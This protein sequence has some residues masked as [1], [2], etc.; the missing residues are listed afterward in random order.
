VVGLLWKEGK[1]AINKGRYFKLQEKARRGG[2]REV[3]D[4]DTFR[5]LL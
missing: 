4:I 2:R 5:E 1:L 3:A